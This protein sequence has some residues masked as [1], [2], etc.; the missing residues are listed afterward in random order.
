MRIALAIALTLTAAGQSFAATY[1]VAPSFVG[2]FSTDGTFTPIAGYELTSGT[3]AILQF[4]MIVNTSGFVAPQQGFANGVFSVE[5]GAGLSNTSAPGW[6]P[7]PIPNVDSNGATP[8]GTVPLLSDNADLAAQD[9]KDIL[10]GVATPLTTNPAVDPRFKFGN[11]TTAN[12]NAG[13][14]YVDYAGGTSKTSLTAGFT[15]VSALLQDGALARYIGVVDANASTPL[16]SVD[17]GPAIPEPTTCILAG[18]A[19][20]GAAARRRV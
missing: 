18:L 15:Q 7:S 12:Y 2:A 9:L 10:L 11:G 16:A 4:D 13:T 8:G 14:I 6:N 3:P 19:L 1:S 5:L 17:I 20:V